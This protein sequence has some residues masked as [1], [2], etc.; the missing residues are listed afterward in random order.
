MLSILQFFLPLDSWPKLQIRSKRRREKALAIQHTVVEIY[1]AIFLIFVRL[2]FFAYRRNTI[3]I[4]YHCWNLYFHILNFCQRLY[5][6]AYRRNIINTYQFE[7]HRFYLFVKIIKII[8]SIIL[9]NEY[10]W[11]ISNQ[12]FSWV[13]QKQTVF[14]QILLY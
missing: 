1:T 11:K 5:L 2:Y 10:F 8:K 7:C 12:H 9:N 4:T 3:K 6:I 14:I 13:T